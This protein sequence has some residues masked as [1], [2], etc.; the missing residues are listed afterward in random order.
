MHKNRS[1]EKIYVT[2]VRVMEKQTVGQ[3]ECE[4]RKR[5]G[6]VIYYTQVLWEK[7]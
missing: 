3:D 4:R 6:E 1:R 5:L 7:T 2:V